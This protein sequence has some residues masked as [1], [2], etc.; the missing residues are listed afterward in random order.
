MGFRLY[1]KDSGGQ[2]RTDLI[3]HIDSFPLSCFYSCNTFSFLGWLRLLAERNHQHHGNDPFPFS[4]NVFNTVHKMVGA[5]EFYH[6]GHEGCWA[7][8]RYNE[9]TPWCL[10]KDVHYKM[11]G[12][13]T[14]QS[15]VKVMDIRDSIS[16]CSDTCAT[17]RIPPLMQAS[18]IRP[19]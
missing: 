14:A 6:S 5:E 7:G 4:P 1:G 13:R 8:S 15:L 18:A 16:I 2:K 12:G 3:W 19:G 17:W 9:D 10:D 11:R